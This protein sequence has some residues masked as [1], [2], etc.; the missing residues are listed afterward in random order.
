[1]NYVTLSR[2]ILSSL[3]KSGSENSP[4]VN[5]R[6]HPYVSGVKFGGR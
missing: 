6:Y 3:M 5:T 1:V 2:T 4:T